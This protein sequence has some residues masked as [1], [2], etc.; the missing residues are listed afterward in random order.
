V[1][2]RLAVITVDAMCRDIDTCTNMYTD[3]CPDYLHRHDAC[4]VLIEQVRQSRCVTCFRFGAPQL[5]LC[6][7]SG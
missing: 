3:M 1:H 6:K 7:V 2:A 4:A 5:M